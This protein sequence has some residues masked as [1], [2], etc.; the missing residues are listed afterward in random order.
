M[1]NAQIGV[2]WH[3][4]ISSRMA[5]FEPERQAAEQAIRAAGMIPWLAENR[6]PE[7]EH[8]T[9]PNE[10]TEAMAAQCDLLL[11]VLGPTYGY[12]PDGQ[13]AGAE[14]SATHLEYEWA[15][16]RRPSK[17]VVFV[18]E[19]A[20][21]TTDAR[22][23]EF[24][25]E[26]SAFS[27]GYTFRK[28]STPDQ[29][30][31]GARLALLARIQQ[32]SLEEAHY[33]EAVRDKYM[34]QTN[35]LTGAEID[36]KTTVL[37][38]VRTELQEQTRRRSWEGDLGEHARSFFNPLARW[39]RAPVGGRNEQP[40]GATITATAATAPEVDSVENFLA[41]YG[42]FVLLGDP[43]AGKSTLLR[44]LTYTAAQRNLESVETAGIRRIPLFVSAAEL[45][46]ALVGGRNATLAD[47]IAS[48][49]REQAIDGADV[50][51]E[52]ALSEN[53]AIVLVDG[54]DE[55]ALE[56][57][58]TAIFEALRRDI[59]ENWAILTS[60]PTAY[61]G[62][63][64]AGWRE[65]EVQQLDDELQLLLI[66][67]VFQQVARQTGRTIDVAPVTLKTELDKREDLRLWAGNPLLLTLISVQYALNGTLP[68]ER[69][70]IYR[71][72]LDR[73]I[74][75]PYRQA[76]PR[77]QRIARDRLE[78]ML[79]RLGLEMMKRSLVSAEL[80]HSPE[81]EPAQDGSGARRG[82][83]ASAS[84]NDIAHLASLGATPLDEEMVNELV[85]RSGVI[86]RQ[87]ENQY[88]FIHLTFQEYFA[89]RAL[90]NP[91]MSPD[92]RKDF[93]VRRRL[94]ARWEQVTRLLVSELD[95]LQAEDQGSSATEAT[96]LV[97]ALIE[98]DRRPVKG[99][100]GRDPLHLS[101][102]RASASQ[103]ERT[104]LPQKT[105][106]SDTING[107]W[108]RLWRVALR[109]RLGRSSPT[110]SILYSV[111]VAPLIAAA[112]GLA[113]VAAIGAGTGI[114]HWMSNILGV[115]FAGLAGILVFGVAVLLELAATGN[116]MRPIDTRFTTYRTVSEG[117]E[118]AAREVSFSFAPL[119]RF[120]RRT[121]YYETLGLVGLVALLIPLVACLL[122]GLGLL[123]VHIPAL[124]NGGF[125]DFLR[126]VTPYG[127]LL[128]VISSLFSWA[129]FVRDQVVELREQGAGDLIGQRGIEDV[130]LLV[131]RFESAQYY[132]YRQATAEALRRIGP[133]AAVA[134]PQ[135]SALAEGRSG[136]YKQQSAISIIG[137]MG[138]A[139]YSAVPVLVQAASSDEPGVQRAAI[140]SLGE[141]GKISEL[142]PELLQRFLEQQV[143]DL[144]SST[145]STRAGARDALIALG[146]AAQPV[147]AKMEEITRKNPSNE[148]AKKALQALLANPSGQ[149]ASTES[150][151]DGETTSLPFQAQIDPN[152]RPSRRD[153]E[154][155]ARALR[156]PE[157]EKRTRAA[158]SI[159]ALHQHSAHKRVV[160]TLTAAM[161]DRNADVRT[162]AL[163]TWAS[164]GL[165]ADKAR[166]V[167]IAKARDR[168]GHL[169]DVVMNILFLLII[170]PA[171][172]ALVVGQL[173]VNRSTASVAHSLG[174]LPSGVVDGITTLLNTFKAH[175]DFTSF[176]LIMS[177]YLALFGIIVFLR[178]LYARWRHTVRDSAMRAL[179]DFLTTIEDA[180]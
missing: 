119:V 20:L 13:P 141:L 89:A 178:V 46:K 24:I 67:G 22:Q 29:L 149:V 72:A 101:L 92:E 59:G 7:F 84:L 41:K 148:E 4:M 140:Q 177:I 70:V 117:E 180:G 131:E 112:T 16:A 78:D 26:V 169:G 96:T 95:R 48:A 129:C 31:E 5:N 39:V 179:P 42:R 125:A 142:D 157:Q 65:C 44:R 115:I 86:Q 105:L 172:L 122:L 106:V 17:I 126:T 34:R 81:D 134:L 55:V 151:D 52:A 56:N 155:L 18:R 79:E 9:S 40:D 54:L 175:A 35:P 168:L 118:R 71:L 47:A 30:E 38:Q 32:E 123:L 94:S 25:R 28:F 147:L 80:I 128:I 51:V 120:M 132:Q 170:W 102:V 76:P 158:Q 154:Q 135:L 121:D 166:P 103:R 114:V 100:G 97:Q 53:R 113:L 93:V 139:G 171:I 163:A 83:G 143:T 77:Q 164:L 165:P 167:L 58:R 173:L 150:D 136:K 161:C 66:S 49:Q 144:Q 145:I 8:T 98:A 176:V 107:R 37:L 111:V 19:D 10:L 152:A 14:K 116:I 91:K 23:R 75:S 160:R 12:Q 21:E 57:Q 99:L 108:Y 43:G 109:G 1:A 133:A 15:R 68:Y 87:S 62:S 73:L 2:F 88:G 27:T 45:G 3:V 90:A 124:A 50:T 127:I 146:Y 11:L 153:I 104:Q 137:G 6:P 159:E 69:A 33:L 61:Q 74:D 82:R 63:S 60:R 174:F 138:A 130:P 36:A 110:T 85:D 156:S 64:L 162:T